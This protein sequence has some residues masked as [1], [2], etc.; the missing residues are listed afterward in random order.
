MSIKPV[1]SILMALGLLSAGVPMP[2]APAGRA[3]SISPESLLQFVSGG[4]ALGFAAGGVYAA[5]GDHA[6]HVDFIGANAVQPQP[7]TGTAEAG[8]KAAP[9]GR[10]V[11]ENLWDGI[12]LAYSAAGGSIYTTTYALAPGA[13]PAAIR[14]SYNVTPVVN[15]DGSLGIAFAAGALTESA[16]AAWQTVD[17]RRVAVEAAFRVRGQEVTFVLGAHDPAYG[18]TIDPALVWNTFLGGSGGDG[19]Y[20]IAVDGN[21]NIYVS[22]ESSASWGTPVRAF[23]GSSDAFVAKI[24]S[25]GSL[26][27]NTFLGGSGADGGYGPAVDG[28]GNVYVAGESSV[29]WGSPV[30]AFGGAYDTFVAKLSV[31]GA[32]LW[33]TFL[34]GS[35]SD[36]GKGIAADSGGNL[37]VTGYSDAAW[38]S[39]KRAYTGDYDAFA[40]S[41][42]SSGGLIW[43]TFLGGS[44]AD[45]GYGI[46]ADGGGKVYVTG[47]SSAAWGSPV[48]AY[49]GADAFAAKLNSSG[50]LIWNTFLGGGGED[51]GFG[52]A[53]DGSGSVYV[54]G[55]SNFS[56]GSPVR[57]YAGGG[58]AFAAKLTSSGSLAWNTFLGGSGLERGYGIAVSVSREIY[59]A[60]Y[61]SATWG[62]PERAYTAGNDGFA[63]KLDSAG[64]LAGNTFL[65][66]S[67]NDYSRAVAMGGSGNVYMTGYGSA[68][69]GSPVRGYTGGNDGF[70]VAM[71]DPFSGCLL[72]G[73]PLFDFDGDCSTDI[74]V[75][76]PSTGAWYIRGRSTVYY[77]SPG[78]K[79]EPG[80]Y[81]GD[82]KTDIAV[83]RPSTG[84]WYIHGRPSVFYGSSGDIPVPGDYD[85][86]GTT[87]IAVYRPSTGAWYIRG[88]PTVYYGASTDIPVPG[89]YTGSGSTGIA[90]YRP[91]TGAWFIRGLSSVY[92]GASGDIPIPGDYDGDS[93]TEIAVYRPSIGR[94]Y[95]RGLPSAYYGASGDIPVPGDYDGDGTTDIAVFRPSTG[96]WYVRNQFAVFYGASGDIPLPELGTGKASTAP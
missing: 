76:R 59:V 36:Y 57:T 65:G 26:V 4:H 91:S 5:A 93:F 19:G 46:S 13:D 11:Y 39:P 96:A 72:K 9:L 60:G 90:V 15:S 17:G 33:N 28:S 79:P 55:Y 63:A 68:V 51:E 49:T 73:L 89:D 2:A 42:N 78:D 48:R 52:I 24:N 45:I 37:Y 43:N 62:S 34:G 3:G 95:I 20:G 83:Y 47:I 27:W 30:R 56:W 29:A 44:G 18:L 16:P 6:L 25:S 53:V 10:V 88:Q 41:L 7:D 40:A 50:A 1:F 85:G 87:D 69:W 80:D 54:A 38:G 23:T 74:A 66:G 82:G 31:S 8:G 22:G 70:V 35:G 94:W 81:D 12:T 21:G 58:D 32:L 86:D 14:L 77:G 84:A 92:Y 67:G 75:Y 61:G 64:S 71:N